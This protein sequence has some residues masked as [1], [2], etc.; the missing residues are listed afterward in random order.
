MASSNP[1]LQGLA[2]ASQAT[3][4]QV[5]TEQK[6]LPTISQVSWKAGEK[7]KNSLNLY[8]IHF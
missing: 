5:A 4:H 7:T 8:E 1:K 2:P 3:Q 6:L